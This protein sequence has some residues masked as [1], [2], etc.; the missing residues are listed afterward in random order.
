MRKGE[1]YR[2][3]PKTQHFFNKQLKKNVILGGAKKIGVKAGKN[4]LLFL[5]LKSLKSLKP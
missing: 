3:S 1:K 5:C 4:N 2:E